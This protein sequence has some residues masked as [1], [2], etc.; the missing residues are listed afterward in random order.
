MVCPGKDLIADSYAQRRSKTKPTFGPA[1]HAAPLSALH[2]P[3]HQ[4]SWLQQQGQQPSQGTPEQDADEERRQSGQGASTSRQGDSRGRPEVP[5]SSKGSSR[6]PSPNSPFGSI[7]L[8]SGR[9][10]CASAKK[11]DDAFETATTHM[12]TVHDSKGATTQHTDQSL[13][14]HFTEAPAQVSQAHRQTFRRQ[15]DDSDRPCNHDCGSHAVVEAECTAATDV[16]ALPEQALQ[17]QSHQAQQSI[18]GPAGRYASSTPAAG[19][20][21][22]MLDSSQGRRNTSNALPTS[23]LPNAVLLLSERPSLADSESTVPALS[24]DTLNRAAPNRDRRRKKSRKH[25]KPGPSAFPQLPYERS[26]QLQQSARALASQTPDSKHVPA[27]DTARQ[28]SARTDILADAM[29]RRLQL[30]ERRADRVLG[31]GADEP[32][33]RLTQHGGYMQRGV[34]ERLPHRR[35]TRSML[36]G[37]DTQTGERLVRRP[38]M[39]C[40]GAMLLWPK[41]VKFFYFLFFLFFFFSQNR[42]LVGDAHSPMLGVS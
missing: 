12:H 27:S 40:M 18:P 11:P 23:V 2:S 33:Q 42:H 17:L 29:Q 25:C 1:S 10:I 6:G 16:E 20:S 37:A 36:R 28:T 31:G 22:P 21:Q 41:L 15:C 26:L 5:S 14:R 8:G 38:L 32:Q 30:Q 13:N 3:P 24:D 19:T 34:Q 4:R 39:H 35:T 7:T 9:H